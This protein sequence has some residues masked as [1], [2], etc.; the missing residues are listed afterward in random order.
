MT[1]TESL[2]ARVAELEQERDRALLLW[3]TSDRFAVYRAAV[4]DAARVSDSFG[5]PGNAVTAA[6]RAL[7]GTPAPPRARR[8][9]RRSLPARQALPARADQ[10]LPRVLDGRGQDRAPHRGRK[11][12]ARWCVERADGRWC[13]LAGRHGR[14]LDFILC[15]GMG[16]SLK[17]GEKNTR[18]QHA[19]RR[20]PTCD[21]C[22]AKK[23][24]ADDGLG[25][26]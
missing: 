13:A 7:S 14:N 21:G 4:E 18:P 26:G 3:R 1:E 25:E 22:K 11:V 10:R 9:D 16:E 17:C 2:S 12:T 24:R 15:G 23:K 5:V 8:G 6:I 20:V 19:R